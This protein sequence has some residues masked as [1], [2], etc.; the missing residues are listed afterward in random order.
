MVLM[1]SAM[2]AAIV[3]DKMMPSILKDTKNVT[4]ISFNV[5]NVIFWINESSADRNATNIVC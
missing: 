1:I 4:N 3:H 2:Q 5:D